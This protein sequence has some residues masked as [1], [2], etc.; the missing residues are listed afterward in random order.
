[1]SI[2]AVLGAQ[3]GD[4]GKG[5]IVSHFAKKF[6]ACV[7]FQGGPN[8]EHTIYLSGKP[9]KLRMI[10]SGIFNTN[11]AIIGNGVFINPRIVL[12]EI[13]ILE[14]DFPDIAEKIL[15]SKKCHI[16]L[17]S[18][19]E[20]DINSAY[21][22]FGTTKM[23]MGPSVADKVSRNG[24][25]LGDIYNEEKMNSLSS[26]DREICERFYSKFKNN[27]IESDIVIRGL[28][29]SNMRIIAEGAQGALLDVDHGDY[30]QVT[31]TNTTIGA[32]LTGL[33]VGVQ[34]V[35]SVYLITSIIMTKVGSGIPNPITGE[36]Q[37]YFWSN[38]KRI[39]K[40]TNTT[41]N[42]GWL[43]I[44]L[45]M[46]SIR[47]NRPTGIILTRLDVLSGL[48]EV[49]YTVQRDGINVQEKFPGWEE[50]ITTI[51][52]QNNLPTNLINFLIQIQKQVGV[53]IVGISVGVND[54]DYIE[55]NL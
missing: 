15:F 35:E 16:I 48:K 4:E 30:P 43:D 22:K 23:G 7:R 17:S 2:A 31:S 45:L 51:R 33:G 8:A 40:T 28:L 41:M 25:R 50:D 21:G 24:F 13:E 18:H 37:E 53:P 36:L 6:D 11:K 27:I 1:M 52:N 3:W 34:D 39:D 32:V 29:D 47:I 12:D 54:D 10:P 38:I 46:K 55:I 5:K 14:S 19:I 44:N 42:F 20:E 49:E 26:E 9:Y